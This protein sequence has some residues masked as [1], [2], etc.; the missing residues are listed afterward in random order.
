[1]SLARL[2][3]KARLLLR[4]EPRSARDVVPDRSEYL[5]IQAEEFLSHESEVP[6]W[7]EG[8]RRFVEETF[9]GVP[10]GA[11]V[12]DCGSGDGVGLAA[13]REM[14]FERL[15][16]VELSPVKAARAR[17]LGFEVEVR[18]MHDLSIFAD[19]SFGAV[20]CSHT[21]EHAHDAAVVLREIRRVLAP[22]GSLHLVLPYPDPGPRNERAHAA[23]YELGTHIAGGGEAVARFIGSAGLDVVLCRQD[24]FREPELWIVARKTG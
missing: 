16:G 19:G 1:L 8:Q 18:D 22:S 20:L 21:L 23:K 12:L 15:A 2:I 13:L 14:G 7:V 10:R 3:R 5:R 6:R 24:A 17:A 11:R 9:A 4:K